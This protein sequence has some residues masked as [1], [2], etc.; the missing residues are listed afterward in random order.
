MSLDDWLVFADFVVDIVCGRNTIMQSDGSARH[1][2]CY[3][4]DATI[5][6]F[7]D[8]L[9]GESGEAYNVGNDQGE[10]SILELANV[11]VGLF[12]EKGLQ[13]SRKGEIK[14][15]GYLKSKITRNCPD[16]SK[17]SALG[18]KPTVSVAEGFNK[19]I[20]SYAL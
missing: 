11:L 1:A 3:L 18:W 4:A 19:T 2:F 17:I 16:I 20:R 6:F 5:G 9:H 7:L 10:L 13:V 14:P 8:L 12:L 15:E